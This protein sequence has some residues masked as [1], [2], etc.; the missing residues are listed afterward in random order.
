[1]RYNGTGIGDVHP[2]GPAVA[3]TEE[4]CTNLIGMYGINPLDGR[5]T[6]K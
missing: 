5:C 4:G 3:G 6:L 1:M 2:D